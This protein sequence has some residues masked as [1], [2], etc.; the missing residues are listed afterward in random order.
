MIGRPYWCR[1]PDGEAPYLLRLLEDAFIRE[2]VT[3]MHSSH[4]SLLYSEEDLVEIVD[5]DN[6]WKYQS[7]HE[8]EVEE[9]NPSFELIFTNMVEYLKLVIKENT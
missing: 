2:Y 5:F 9:L 6:Y 1:I 4:D 7:W 3:A 8:S